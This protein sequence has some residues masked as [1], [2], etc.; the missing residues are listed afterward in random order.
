MK[1]VTITLSNDGFAQQ[2]SNVID[3]FDMERGFFYDITKN[4]LSP[5]QTAFIFDDPDEKAM[6]NLGVEYGKNLIKSGLLK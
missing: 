4:R 2:L 6:F 3:W 1:K 5:K